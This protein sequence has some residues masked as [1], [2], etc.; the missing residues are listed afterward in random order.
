MTAIGSLPNLKRLK[1]QH[2]DFQGAEWKPNEQEAEP[3]EPGWELT[4]EGVFPKLEFLQLEDL[5][6]VNWTAD[7]I[8]CFVSLKHLVIRYCC[9]LKEIPFAIGESE[10]LEKIEVDE[11]NPSVVDS[12]NEIEE[13]KLEKGIFYM[14]Y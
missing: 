7:D 2:S 13:E 10:S 4:E 9:S 12:A 6:L 1:I 8:S 14:I 3:T 11:S 5:N